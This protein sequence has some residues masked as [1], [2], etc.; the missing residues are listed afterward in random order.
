MASNLPLTQKENWAPNEVVKPEHTNSWGSS[1]NK[2]TKAIPIY[3]SNGDYYKVESFSN[4]IINLSPISDKDG[5]TNETVS[6]YVDGMQVIFQSTFDTSEDC[7]VNIN[8]LGVKQIKTIK[9]VT[10]TSGDIISGHFIKLI[11]S[12]DA[13]IFYLIG[14]YCLDKDLSNLDST[15]LDKLNISKMYT[16]GNVSTDTQGYNQLVEM[17]RS[18]FDKS[19]FTVIGTPTITD[20]G[21]ASGFSESNYIKT[22]N[23]P[24]LGKITESIRFTSSFVYNTISAEQTIWNKNLNFD[25][26]LNGGSIILRTYDGSKANTFS[27]LQSQHKVANGEQVFCDV[28]ITPNLCRIKINDVEFTKEQVT[29]FSYLINS[30]DKDFR[31]GMSNAFNFYFRTSIDLKVFSIAVDGKEVF[32]GNKTGIDTI[33]ADNYE[34]VGSPVISDDGIASGFL[35]DIETGYDSSPTSVTPNFNIQQL[36]NKKWKIECVFTIDYILDKLGGCLY[37]FGAHSGWIAWS[38]SLEVEYSQEICRLKSGARFGDVNDDSKNVI[39][40]AKTLN[41]LGIVKN[42]AYKYVAMFDGIDTYTNEIVDMEN[43]KVILTTNYKPTTTNKNLYIINTDA[44]SVITIGTGNRATGSQWSGWWGSI[45]LNSFKIYVDGNLVYQPCLKIPYTQSKTG[46]KVVDDGY[47]DR[48]Q[49]VYEQEGKADYYTIDEENQNFTLPM[50]EIYGMINSIKLSSGKELLEIYID[51]FC[52][53]SENKGRIA[54]GQIIVQNQFPEATKKLKKRVGWDSKN[55]K[56]TLNT[57]LVCT[58]EEWQA[59]KTASKL[60]QCGKFVIDDEAGTIR[61][62]AIVNINGLTDLSNCGLIKDESLPAHKHTR[63]TMEISGSL[64]TVHQ[65]GYYEN[66]AFYRSWNGTKSGSGGGNGDWSNWE[67]RA[68]RN[69]TG[70]T[71]TPDN[72]TYQDNAPVQQEA[73]QYPYVICVNTGVEEAERPINNYQVNN[74]NSLLEAKYTDHILN[75]LSWLRSQGQYNS[76]TIYNKAYELILKIYNGTET[77]EGIS[78]KAK[79]D[80]SI[81]DYDFVIDTTNTEFRLPIKSRLAS[82]KAVV[83]NGVALGITD[84]INNFGL[85]GASNQPDRVYRNTGFY[86]K[87]TGSKSEAGIMLAN[88][89]ALGVTTDGSKSGIETDDTG[90]YLYYYVGDTLQNADLINIARMQEQITDINAPTRGYLVES[91]VKGQSGYRLYSDGFCEQRGCFNYGSLVADNVGR[92]ITLLKPFKDNNYSITGNI[93]RPDKTASASNGL[94]ALAV[95]FY[96]QQTTGFYIRW[97]VAPNT[98]ERAQY[99][100]WEA[101]GYIR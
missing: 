54:N 18:T 81:T 15:G 43:K 31:I 61:L 88:D 13:D 64:G 37:T 47:R 67:F 71:S 63:G 57:S 69:W 56:A 100:F 36:K 33:K 52:D 75:N 65:F 48:V 92:A 14:N 80:S 87:N 55:Q 24:E 101:R 1:I 2:L 6:S 40:F 85:A 49:D 95:G 28:V 86:G 82:G 66:G 39:I 59:I 20:D 10:V 16:T 72:A 94:C 91:Y 25:F 19:K 97:Y 12:K 70:S 89:N 22:P 78:V 21:V 44:E 58:E 45:D 98:N 42:K 4:N 96:A 77:I 99:A 38:F 23:V 8:E 79:G 83:G 7:S 90:L 76:G 93:V 46:S 17:K 29:D 35:K 53:E 9:N 26:R 51:P 50:G 60:G 5:L 73:V 41:E 30:G 62:P 32:S 34:V 68:S 27:I 74:T 3:A 11:Y 84:T